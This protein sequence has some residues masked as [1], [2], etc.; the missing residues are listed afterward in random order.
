MLWRAKLERT[1]LVDIIHLGIP[2]PEWQI[3]RLYPQIIDLAENSG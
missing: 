2:L 1:R 3:I